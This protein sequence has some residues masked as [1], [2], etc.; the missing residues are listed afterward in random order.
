MLNICMIL[1]QI[2]HH[3]TVAHTCPSQCSM[4][5]MHYVPCTCIPFQY[6]PTI[7]SFAVIPQ[8]LQFHPACC[9]HFVSV[10]YPGNCFIP[11]KAKCTTLCC[12]L[13]HL[14]IWIITHVVLPWIY[15]MLIQFVI[16]F[17]N[18]VYTFMHQVFIKN[19]KLQMVRNCLNNIASGMIGRK[20]FLFSSRLRLAKKEHCISFSMP[21][22]VFFMTLQ[23]KYTKQQYC[24]YM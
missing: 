11:L 10:S 7:V 2:W 24:I 9:S 3:Q 21:F 18:T 8:Q 13:S 6:A 15:K 12:M 22:D 20:F 4:H 14:Y 1:C 16:D 23:K 5:Y 19:Y 17:F